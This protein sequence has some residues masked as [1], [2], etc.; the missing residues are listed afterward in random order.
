MNPRVTASSGSVWP[1]RAVL[2]LSAAAGLGT[3]SGVTGC[4]SDGS[5]GAQRGVRKKLNN[6]SDNFHSKGFPIVDKP[7]TIHF[8]TGKRVV[9]ADDYNK[10]A[11]WKKY[12]KKTNIKVEW[13]LV[14]DESLEEKR[15]LD[16]SSGDYPEALHKQGLTNLDIGKYANQDVFIRLNDLIDKY[17]PNLQKAMDDYPTVRKGMT[18]PDGGMYGMPS[19]RAPETPPMRISFMLWVR[20]DWLDKL[21][22]DVPKT[23]DEY[24]RYLKAVKDKQPNGKSKAIGY[25]DRVEG[26]RLMYSLMGSF[27]IGNR[28]PGTLD[29]EPEDKN[30]VRYIPITDEYKALLEY[31]H[32]L[33]SDGLIAKNIFSIDQAK[34]KSAMAKGVYGS[35]ADIAPGELFGGK[36]TKFASLPALKGPDGE[37]AYINVH[38]PLLSIGNFVITDKVKHPAEIARW[39][40]YFY[41]DEG[42]KLYH[43]GI[44]GV[45][46][47][48]TKNGVEFTDKITD[49]PKGLTQVEAKK[50]YV[51]QSGGGY[52][53]IIKADYFKGVETSPAATKAAKLLDSDVPEEIWP[54]FTYT[55]DEAE[56][57]NSLSDDID[58]YVD[59]SRDKFMTGDK[60]LSDW[61]KYVDKIKQMGLDDYMEIQQAAYDR[62][63]KG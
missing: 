57:L 20:K 25:I 32:R 30:K 26:S 29:A 13:G 4:S 41:S 16:L 38:T 15:N 10:V 61:K 24:Y 14:P 62:Y 27:G 36:A 28:G 43:M 23:T 18:F 53:G 17:M 45:T 19:I 44:K 51:T 31:L 47:K 2:S 56:K 60:P 5:S 21:D 11:V 46:Y 55:Q 40:D 7:I 34:L 37:H 48:S 52:P 9:T 6:P 8:M 59:E 54:D 12:Q 50:P 35:I 63:R 42:T 33:Y 49:N 22:M 3:V 1:R 39:L 58:K